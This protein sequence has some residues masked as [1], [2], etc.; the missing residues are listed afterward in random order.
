MALDGTAP[1]ASVIPDCASGAHL[2]PRTHRPML[3]IDMDHEQRG[4]CVDA[5]DHRDQPVHALS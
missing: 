4:R 2:H 1:E 5:R 3:L